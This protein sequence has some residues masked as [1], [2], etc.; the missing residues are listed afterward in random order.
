MIKNQ[1]Y[2]VLSSRELKKG[3]LIGVTR[4]G[5]KLAFWRDSNGK[6]HCISDICCHRGA[7]IS[8]G[9]VLSN[10]ERV[11]CPFHG[12]EYDSQGR[13]RTIPANG[14]NTPVPEN[15][16][17][18]S[19]PTYELADFIWIWYGD[20]E[21]EKPPKYFDDITDELVYTEFKE[22]WNVHYSRAIENQLDPIHLPFVHYNTIG[23]GNRTV[24]DGPIVE[25]KDDEMFYFYVFN[26]I[27][28]GTPARKPEEMDPKRKSKVYLEFKFP[29]IWQN[30]I[31]EKIRVTAAFTPIDDDHTMIYL[32]FY[33][34][35][36]GIKFLDK[37]IAVLGK[38][39]NKIVLHQDKRVVETQ[40]PK[41][42]ELRMGENLIP[43]DAPILEYRKKREALK[44]MQ[45]NNRVK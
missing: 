3:Q 12:F 43:G 32:R 27:D 7:S 25:W 20:R 11:M 23:R 8:H 15:F 17:V 28:D 29:N 30:H 19:Y 45:Q 34:G 24:V 40:I 10:G 9:K 39:F 33:V 42:S 5:E 35:L 36:T 14:R 41:R 22:V 13:V 31:S 1:W 6:V 18:K 37:L 4:F 26:R 2:V 44:S 16:R 21:P 38:P